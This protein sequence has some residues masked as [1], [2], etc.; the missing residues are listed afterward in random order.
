ML[1]V[2]QGSILGYAAFTH[3]GLT[4]IVTVPNGELVK[5][6]F[7]IAKLAQYFVC[8]KNRKLA[9]YRKQEI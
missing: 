9:S 4:T 3:A 6:Y 2:K 5:K 1:N 8:E 7:L